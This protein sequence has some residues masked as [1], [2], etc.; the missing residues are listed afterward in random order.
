MLKNNFAC[1]IIGEPLYLDNFV[2]DNNP[3]TLFVVGNKGGLTEVR[4]V[5]E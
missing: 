5:R 4:R 1:F 2:R 3:P